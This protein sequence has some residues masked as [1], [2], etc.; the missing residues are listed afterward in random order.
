MAYWE[1][2]GQIW[3]DNK[4]HGARVAENYQKNIF[5]MLI[6]GAGVYKTIKDYP[7][8]VADIPYR[9]FEAYPNAK[10]VLVERD[11]EEWYDSLLR[12]TYSA[13]KKFFIPSVQTNKIINFLAYNLDLMSNTFG[14]EID[15]KEQVIEQYLKRNEELKTFFSGKPNFYLLKFSEDLNW[16]TVQKVTGIETEGIR[17]GIAGYYKYI[18]EKHRKNYMGPIEN[19]D[20]P[21]DKW[22]FPRTNNLTFKHMMGDTVVWQRTY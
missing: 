16:K 2:K 21:I 3:M 14:A 17:Q 1:R 5:K 8:N 19:A 4:I 9:L 22:T 18:N 10:F 12:W 20:D 7:W 13:P 11:T 15:Q 6:R